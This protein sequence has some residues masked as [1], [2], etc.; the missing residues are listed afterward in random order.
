M[1]LSRFNFPNKEKTTMKRVLLAAATA[2]LLLNTLA[3]PPVAH[4]DG[5]SSGCPTACKP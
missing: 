1:K 3:I 2:I 4:A 5:V